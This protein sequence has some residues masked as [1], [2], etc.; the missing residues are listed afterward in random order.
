MARLRSPSLSPT[1]T[2]HSAM[3]FVAMFASP[4]RMW[5]VFRSPVPAGNAFRDDG[6]GRLR[7]VW[8]V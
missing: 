3:L 4:R 7:A 2:E 8:Q 1:V 5:W 6:V